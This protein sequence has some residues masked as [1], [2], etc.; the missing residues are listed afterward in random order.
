MR[1]LLMSLAL[2][3][4]A[5]CS[6]ATAV[7]FEE[8]DYQTCFGA[9]QRVLTDPASITRAIDACNVIIKED[10]DLQVVALAF[11]QRGDF[12]LAAREY[13]VAV[14]DFDGALQVRANMPE[15]L[16]GKA[17]GQEMMGDLV[18]AAAGFEQVLAG[19][20]N[21][22]EANFLRGRLALAQ[23]DVPRALYHISKA[24]QLAPDQ[25]EYLA[26]RGG[27][28]LASGDA[29]GAVADLDGALRLE[30][31]HGAA[32]LAMARALRQLGEPRWALAFASEA[33]RVGYDP[34]QA[35]Y[36]AGEAH[37]LIGETQPAIMRFS[38][39]LSANPA[40]APAAYGRALARI[41]EG[42]LDGALADLSTAISIDA[43][44][45]PAY[46]AR[47][48]LHE[49]KGALA[50]AIEDWTRLVQ[51]APADPAPLIRRGWVNAR[52]GQAEKALADLDAALRLEPAN[53]QALAVRHRVLAGLGREPE[54][55]T[56][57][58]ALLASV[59]AVGAAAPK[60]A[61][62]E[63][64]AATEWPA[65]LR[66]VTASA[67]RLPLREQ[68]IDRDAEVTREV[69]LLAAPVLDATPS[70]TQQAGKRVRLHA[71]VEYAQDWGCGVNPASARLIWYRISAGDGAPGYLKATDMSALRLIYAPP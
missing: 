64:D 5:A 3:A 50:A 23:L 26:M 63:A 58:T 41:M 14:R 17:R 35:G 57:L 51:M 55:A 70:Q 47:A 19:D 8:S 13:A 54:A 52:A 42:D 69:T 44:G 37:R 45:A 66:R 9:D 49:R 11:V 29:A 40:H 38:A 10:G 24:V 46:A 32:N 65:V 12:S 27:A 6:S 31:S 18:G 53:R 2:G 25:A 16:L 20:P 22:I 33:L 34:A 48:M 1:H 28:C 30:P 59:E 68:A 67:A 15:A 36:E 43:N 56:A 61:A 39:L 4:I 60:R 62:T 21:S 71:R 7:A